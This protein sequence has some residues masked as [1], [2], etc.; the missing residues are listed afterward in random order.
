M[1]ISS[2]KR[3]KIQTQPRRVSAGGRAAAF[4]SDAH[5]CK[6]AAAA[7]VGPQ[8]GLPETKSQQPQ[9]ACRD[10]KIRMNDGGKDFQ[11][12]GEPASEQESGFA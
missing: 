9:K 5:T 1:G 6:S 2:I 10:I 7:H 8:Q 12:S 11:K 4:G 3:N